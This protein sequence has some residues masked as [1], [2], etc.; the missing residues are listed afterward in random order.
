MTWVRPKVFVN[1][2]WK[3]ICKY[4]DA[5]DSHIY[6][7]AQLKAAN[8]AA[9]SLNN[10]PPIQELFEGPD[11]VLLQSAMEEGNVN[12][13]NDLIESA[14]RTHGRHWCYD[15]LRYAIAI[16][17]T[18]SPEVLQRATYSFLYDSFI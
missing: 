3:G 8:E 17:N 1:G 10:C 2:L 4:Y 13:A 14:E 18:C 5:R 9:E 7:N 11:T 12:A 16:Y 6:T 15:A